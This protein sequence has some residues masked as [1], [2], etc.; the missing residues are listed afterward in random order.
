MIY[1]TENSA[2]VLKQHINA[3]PPPLPEYVRFGVKAGGC[4]GFTYTIDFD[5]RPRKF[6]L[7]FESFGIMYW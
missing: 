2:K 5:S 3:E 6:D 1:L 4:S 7:E